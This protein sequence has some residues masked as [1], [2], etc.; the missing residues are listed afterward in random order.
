VADGLPVFSLFR[1]VLPLTR[2]LRFRGLLNGTTSVILAS[3]EQGMDWDEAIKA[4]QDLGIAET[5][6]SADI[7]GWDA[8]VKVV[9][10]A[11]VLMDIPLKLEQV[12]RVGIRSLSAEQIRWARAQ[13]RPY[14]L[15]SRFDR[16]ATGL[17]TASVRPEQ[18]D[19]ASLFGS[20]SPEALLLQFETDTIPELTL[21]EDHA[22]PYTTAYGLLSDFIYATRS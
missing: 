10:L 7:E 8:A 15:I 12:E 16:D 18:V 17:L 20:A 13:G 6:P 9:A 14:K 4:A 19:S 22:G 1:E 2:L 21:M 3:I 5:D 11:T